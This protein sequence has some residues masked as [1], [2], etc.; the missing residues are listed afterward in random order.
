MKRT[1]GH[2]SWAQYQEGDLHH[3]P[4]DLSGLLGEGAFG[5]VTK[6]LRV[7][8][9][10]MD[11]LKFSKTFPGLH[12][13]INEEISILACTAEEMVFMVQRGG[14]VSISAPA[15]LSTMISGIWS[16]GATIS[17]LAT[18]CTT[19]EGE[20]QHDEMNQLSMMFWTE[21]RTPNLIKGEPGSEMNG[22]H[23]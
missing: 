6:C 7:K 14:H 11:A 1:S 9:G 22:H 4:S 19:F 20:E 8:T 15:E 16:V 5:Y 12:P 13:Q 18:A 2:L 21:G 10:E 17:E 23:F 3:K